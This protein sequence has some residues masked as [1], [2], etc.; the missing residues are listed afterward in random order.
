MEED[1]KVSRRNILAT[2]VAVGCWGGLPGHAWPEPQPSDQDP[3]QNAQG[4]A[5]GSAQG[6][7][8]AAPDAP[9][10][11]PQIDQSG[12]NQTAAVAWDPSDGPNKPMGE[13]RGIHPGRV[14]W[15]HNPDVATWD[16]VTERNKVVKSTGQWWDDENCNPDICTDMMSAAVLNL[17]AEKS[18]KKAWELIFKNYNDTHGF[19]NNA[20]KPGEKITIKV[21][22]NN[23]RSNTQPWTPGRGYPSPQLLQAFLRQLVQNAGVPGED[24][25]VFDGASGRFISDP[26]FN[27]IMADP[28]ERLH[29]IHF[30]VNPPLAARGRDPVEADET[31]PIKFSDP[32][33]GRVFPAEVR[34]GSEV[35]DQL[36]IAPRARNLRHNLLHEEQ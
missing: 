16:G 10:G 3:A 6:A 11:P 32:E 19:G 14:V 36:R 7:Q 21:N 9:K 28:D 4:A 12:R 1:K 24:I 20:Y 8:G 26:V 2:T 5:Q 27:R 13:G 17:A 23:D 18:E 34:G 33:G 22:F 25:T 29:K 35:P 31:D 30:Q 15:I